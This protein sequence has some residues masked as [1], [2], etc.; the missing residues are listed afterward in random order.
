MDQNQRFLDELK[1]TVTAINRVFALIEERLE[2][3]ETYLKLGPYLN[4]LEIYDPTIH[5]AIE[6][7]REQQ[8]QQ[9][10]ESSG[11]QSM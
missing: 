8:N 3:I 10:N 11:A 1:F 4:A 9:K 6:D 5:I 7:Q 2:R